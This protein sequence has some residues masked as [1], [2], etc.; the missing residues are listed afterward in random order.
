MKWVISTYCL[1]NETMPVMHFFKFYVTGGG[2]QFYGFEN[3]S[4][5][6]LK[7]I[8]GHYLH[9]ARTINPN[10]ML[11]CGDVWYFHTHAN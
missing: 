4:N 6:A 9:T 10:L 5:G 1:H 7:Y 11:R 8:S 3:T 2:D